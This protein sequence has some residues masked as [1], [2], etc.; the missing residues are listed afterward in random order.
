LNTQFAKPKSIPVLGAIALAVFLAIVLFLFSIQRAQ[1]FNPYVKG[2]LS[3]HGDRVQGHAIFQMN[4]AGCHGLQ[5]DGHI[6]PSLKN[7][8]GRKSKIALIQQVTGGKTPPMPQ[9]QPNS[10][11]MADLL[12]YL[13]SL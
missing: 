7:I 5:A 12:S 11:E 9:F 8:S 3:M 4:C 6:G 1:A 2:V 13:E 10:T